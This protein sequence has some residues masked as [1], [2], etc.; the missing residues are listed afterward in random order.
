MQI[1]FHVLEDQINISVIL[2]FQ[3]IQQPNKRVVEKENSA[4]LRKKAAC[5]MKAAVRSIDT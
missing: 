3:Y 1:S 5:D 2:R 4:R